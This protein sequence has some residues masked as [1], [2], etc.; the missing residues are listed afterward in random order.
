MVDTNTDP[1][2][3]TLYIPDKQT[4]KP[5]MNTTHPRLYGHNL[6]MFAE[7]IRMALAAKSVTYQNDEMDLG[8][9]TEWHTSINGGLIPI[10]EMPDGEQIRESK[11]LLDFFEDAYPT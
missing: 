8:K 2:L 5:A 1:N 10:F 3:E 11:V 9:K 6:C 7:K 4:P